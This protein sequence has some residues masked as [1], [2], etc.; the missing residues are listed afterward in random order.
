MIVY[1]NQETIDMLLE[2][3]FCDGYEYAQKEFNYMR[4]LGRILDKEFKKGRNVYE[5]GDIQEHL[6]KAVN[7]ERAKNGKASR[8]INSSKGSV[9]GNEL[10]EV[11]N[12]NSGMTDFAADKAKRLTTKNIIDQKENAFVDKK[13]KKLLEQQKL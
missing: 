6:T 13:Y 9:L 1:R 7:K 8:L 3:A 5:L 10:N 4:S 12:H 11:E 2:K